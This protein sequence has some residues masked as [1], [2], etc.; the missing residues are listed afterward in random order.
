M[1]VKTSALRK[2]LENLDYS[3][4][5]NLEEYQNKYYFKKHIQETFPEI[6]DGVI[7]AAIEST[8]SKFPETALSRRY[9]SDLCED[10]FASLK[11]LNGKQQQ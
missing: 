10:I 7:Y 2:Y 1:G 5:S 9:I 4:F 11:D 8:N 6:E 3:S